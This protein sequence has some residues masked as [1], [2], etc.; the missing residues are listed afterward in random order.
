MPQLSPSWLGLGLVA[1]SPWLLL[2]LAGA[3]WLLDRFLA[4]TCAFWDSCRCLKYFPQPPK[5]KWVWGHQDLITAM[6]EG[7]KNL[8]QMSATYSQ[9]FRIWMDSIFPFIVLCHPNIIRSITN[10]SG[11]HAE[12]AGVGAG[13]FHPRASSFFSPKLL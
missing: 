2:L 6:E 5:Q 1:A 9:D 4:W 11:I 13:G 3:S 10:A 12:L 8:T 7:L